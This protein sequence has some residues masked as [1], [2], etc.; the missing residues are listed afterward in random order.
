MTLRNP[1]RLAIHRRSDEIAFLQYRLRM[2]SA[3]RDTEEQPHQSRSR[4]DRD[5]PEAA[6]AQYDLSTEVMKREYDLADE[7]LHTRQIEP[8]GE[9]LQRRLA[10]AER[11]CR[12]LAVRTEPSLQSPSDPGESS[13]SHQP[14][15]EV[16][17]FASAEASGGEP[18]REQSGEPG[19]TSSRDR[20]PDAYWVAETERRALA[21]MLKHWWAWLRES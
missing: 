2:L 10:M 4:D 7:L 12:D 5:Q 18:Q 19:R 9:T 11:I 8:L 16:E 6:A 17:G 3:A 21:E 14:R 1:G 13:S 20:L 15:A